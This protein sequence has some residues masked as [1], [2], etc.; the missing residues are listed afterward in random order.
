MPNVVSVVFR[1]GG[2]LY[3]FDPHGLELVAGDSVIVETARGLDF[4]RVVKDA[5]QVSAADLPAGLKRVVRKA[6]GADLETRCRNR[7]YEAEALDVCRELAAELGLDMKPVSAELSFDGRKILV[8]FAAEERVDF[9][10]LVSKL[11]DRLQRRVELKQVSARDEAR[12]VGGYGSCGRRL[13]CS[14]FAGD[15]D[16]VSIRMAKDQDL[17]LNPTKISGV[18]GRLMCCLKYEHG[19][20]VTFRKCAPKKGTTI[21]TPAGEGKVI[22]LAAPADSVTVDHGEGR[23]ATYRLSELRPAKE[24]S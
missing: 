11:S 4:G 21:A 24:D 3:H 6:S 23:V 12:L 5:E 18:C 22:D 19:A 10:G 16:P 17:P 7:A 8:S 15:Q 9:R 1:D 20:Y 14:L 13:C 2:K